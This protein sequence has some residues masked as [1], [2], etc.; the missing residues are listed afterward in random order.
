VYFWIFGL[1]IIADYTHIKKYHYDAYKQNELYVYGCKR[2]G[3]LD[4]ERI[5]SLDTIGTNATY[6][7]INKKID[8]TNIHY[9]R[10][11]G[12]REYEISDWRGNVNAVIT[13]RRAYDSNGVYGADIATSTDYYA[14]GS[15]KLGR[16]WMAGD[17]NKYHFGFNSKWNDD[18]VYGEGGLEDYGKRMYD[19]LLNRFISVDPITDKYPELTTYQFASNSPIFA[20]D[21]DGLEA[22]GVTVGYR[23]TVLNFTFGYSYMVV[24]TLHDV[25]IYQTTS[26][27]LGA[28][29]Y[30][31]I[32]GA[33]VVYP[34]A[35]SSAELGGWGTDV[36]INAA[37]EASI[38]YDVYTSKTSN[39]GSQL[40]F[41]ASPALGIGAGAEGHFAATYSVLIKTWSFGDAKSKVNEM[42]EVMGTNTK[43]AGD[44][45]NKVTSKAETIANNNAQQNEKQND[46][47]VQTANPIKDK[48]N[49]Y[50]IKKGDTLSGIAKKYNT[51]V[52]NLADKNHI[53][54]PNRIK[55]GSKINVN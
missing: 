20:V 36:G 31:G 37:D 33:I 45:L 6:G 53:A 17:S 19:A 3:I 32:S 12:E 47:N 27:G 1:Y 9:S 54:D 14:F 24:A 7:F 26:F 41:D 2:L 49:S 55:A 11:K 10:I 38:G 13:D 28:G 44:A 15:E 4:I 5:L 50:T 8:S 43:I 46:N 25:S 16:N 34:G 42:A 29:M 52:K 18:E 23:S 51:S 39:D 40:G 30:I 48:N 35:K 21:F 22:A